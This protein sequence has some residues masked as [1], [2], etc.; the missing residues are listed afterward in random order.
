[1]AHHK[2]HDEHVDRPAAAA[3]AGPAAARTAPAVHRGDAEPG[4]HRRPGAPA[5]FEPYDEAFAAE[6]LAAART[7]WTPRRWPTR[8]STP[9]ARRHRRRPVRRQQRHRRVLLGGGR[10]VPHHRREGVPRRG[11][12][13]AAAH[14]RRV[15]PR[16]LRLGSAPPRSAAST[17]PRSPTGCPTAAGCA[18]PWWTAPTSTWPTSQASPYGIAVRA[19]QRHVRLGLQQPVLNNM[20]VLAIA[21]DITGD[22]QYRDGVL[23]GHGLHPRPQRAEPVLRHRLRRGAT[24]TTSTAAGTPTSST[25]GCPTRRRAPLA[26]GPNSVHPGPGGPGAS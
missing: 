15:R 5:L 24:R 13:V 18:H 11:D 25:R 21:F 1:M 19:E 6:C 14:R 8:T 7:A 26:G 2:I 17:W 22:T 3:A 20:V 16:R 9:P 10:A 4:R 23:R 12:L